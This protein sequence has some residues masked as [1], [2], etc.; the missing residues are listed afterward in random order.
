MR[1][2]FLSVVSLIL[3]TIMTLA[4]IGCSA[5]VDYNPTTPQTTTPQTPQNP[6]TPE[7]SSRTNNQFFWG[8][9]VR[10]DNGVEYEILETTVKQGLNSYQITTFGDNSIT[11]SAL[12]IFYKESERVIVCNNIPYFRKGGVNLEYSLK[13]VGFTSQS[14]RIV[15]TGTQGITA[16]GKSTKYGSFE[17]QAESDAEGKITLTAPT[18][19]DPQT[20][21]I[22]NGENTIVIPGITITNSG[23]YMGT[24]ALVGKDD[25]NLK[26]TGTI[27]L[28]QKDGGYLFGNN[29]KSYNMVLTITNISNNKCSTSACFIETD[30]AKLSINSTDGTNLDGFTI[31]TLAG[32][33][34]KKV[35]LSV[36]YGQLSAP[37]INTG[38]TV[39][40]KNPFTNQEWKDYIP[41]RFY[42]GLIPI[43]IAAKNPE[44]NYNAVLNGFVIYPDGNNQFFAIPNNSS[45]TI[46]VPTFESNKSY[47]LVFS[48]ATV[49]SELSDSTEMYYTV[50]PASTESRTVVTNGS[51]ILSYIPFGGENHSER[52]A[53]QVTEGFE[54]YLREGEIDYYSITTSS[55]G[56]YSP[57]EMPHYKVSFVN[58]KGEA[59][60]SF[61]V[62]YDSVLSSTQLPELEYEGYNF[63][64]WYIG[65]IKIVS[66]TFH[67]RSVV[68]LTAKW[69]PTNYVISY[70]LN[71]GSNESSNPSS[72][73]ILSDTI[74]LSEPIKNGY[75]FKGWYFTKNFTGNAVTHIEKGSLG[76]K[77][78][79]AKWSPVSYLIT[80]ILNGGTNATGNPSSYNIE[81][82]NITLAEPTKTGDEFK[83]W[84]YT[85][86]FTG[87]AITHIEKGSLGN[88]KL[89]AKWSSVS[90]SITYILNG[91]INAVENPSSYNKETDTITLSEPIR[92]GYE[93]KGWYLTENFTGNTVTHIEKGSLGNKKLYAKWN[94]IQ[95]SI[96]Y[97]LNG[98]T[99]ASGNPE[100][101]TIETG[102]ITLSE[103]GKQ[104][105]LFGGWY[106]NSTYSGTKQTSIDWGSSGNKTYYAKWLKKCTITY[107]TEHGTVP[108]AITVWEGERLSTVQLPEL[109]EQN[110]NFVGWYTDCNYVK[111]KKASIRQIV[112]D[113]LILY[114]K[115]VRLLSEQF[116]EQFVNTYGSGEFYKYWH[117]N[118]GLVSL[119]EYLDRGTS[120]AYFETNSG[121]KLMIDRPYGDDD[122]VA[123]D[124]NG[125]FWVF[126]TKN[127]DCSVKIK[128]NNIDIELSPGIY[129]Y[130]TLYIYDT[131]G[132]AH[133]TWSVSELTE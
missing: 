97:V 18:A 19:D 91:G 47:M 132:W 118:L 43:T 12:G 56:Y 122:I 129:T 130:D 48:G 30:D 119:Q 72:Y 101:Y 125:K 108:S 52:A 131:N 37:Y 27:S 68:T 39:T 38:I 73:T 22:V 5:D 23:D 35:N 63:L 92:T 124:S 4:L 42:K 1:Q 13:L 65:N 55:Q 105:F 9:W 11:V 74:T 16:R 114:G 78:L 102:T 109:T 21:T 66:D 121:I 7:I 77:K 61:I 46:F 2:R 33:A 96:T 36:K 69:E 86:N 133:N 58:D 45:N 94:P 93:F 126:N 106:T 128:I 64:G 41:L 34:T 32:G 8:T 40:I 83:G 49:T 25:Y 53:Y 107:I 110:W 17:C 15:A 127:Y 111:D 60:Q 28:D 75:E 71:G 6:E 90:Y 3:T 44:N 67:V 50:E 116:A 117:S 87:N 99:N 70:E 82:E 103:P 89:Y 54:A 120:L 10:M 14:S 81:T 26:I 57:G 62:P 113:N 51:E 84:Y 80:Y 76:N 20:V 31:S 88:K 104:D 29:A 59:P 24:V 85:E 79:Y 100:S 112:T 115:W 98:G 95:Y 123:L